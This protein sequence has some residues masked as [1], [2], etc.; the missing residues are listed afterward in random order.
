MQ[1]RQSCSS[2]LWLTPTPRR[3]RMCAGCAPMRT[4]VQFLSSVHV[5]LTPPIVLLQHTSITVFASLLAQCVSDSVINFQFIAMYDEFWREDQF[6]TFR[7]F[8]GTQCFPQEGSSQSGQPGVKIHFT[9]S[10]CRFILIN[11]DIRSS[12]G[13]KWGDRS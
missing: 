9:E 7:H 13:Q 10:V 4:V 5:S 3:L 8:D 6:Q 2:R 11:V 12:F 1:R